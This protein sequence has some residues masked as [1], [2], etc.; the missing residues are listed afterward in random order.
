LAVTLNI[1][2]VDPKTG[3]LGKKRRET[4]MQLSADA[5]P[6]DG[7]FFLG[8]EVSD[9]AER[10]IYE[11]YYEPANNR[12]VAEMVRWE[13]SG[14]G[15]VPTKVP[16]RNVLLPMLGPLKCTLSREMKRDQPGQFL[17]LLD[18]ALHEGKNICADTD[19]QAEVWNG[20]VT[21]LDVH[22]VSENR[23]A[24]T[25]RWRVGVSARFGDATLDYLLRRN[26]AGRAVAF[27]PATDDTDAAPWPDFLWYD[28]PDVGTKVYDDGEWLVNEAMWERGVVD[29]RPDDSVPSGFYV[30]D[31]HIKHV[32]ELIYCG[33]AGYR[34]TLVHGNKRYGFKDQAQWQRAVDQLAQLRAVVR[35]EDTADGS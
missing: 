17:A 18:I 9:A 35:F 19:K 20:V 22:K 13:L 12:I 26:T 6:E 30:Y 27:C 5:R 23:E 25:E 31:D 11:V 10:L 34:H 16:E 1:D 14:D 32:F 21:A 7:R 8:T 24:R 2:T 29:V 33:L 4:V 15:Y 28:V 3:Y